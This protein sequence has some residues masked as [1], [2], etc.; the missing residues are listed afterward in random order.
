[1]F[2]S[3]AKRHKVAKLM[4]RKRDGVGKAPLLDATAQNGAKPDFF[5]RK[6]TRRE[7]CESTE[8]V[9][10]FFWRTGLDGVETSLL[11]VTFESRY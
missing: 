8:T 11:D 6:E 5:N 1:M 3:F 2:V 4:L 7:L 10:N 9:C